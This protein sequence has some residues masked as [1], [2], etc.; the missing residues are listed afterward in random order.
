MGRGQP[1][2]LARRNSWGSFCQGTGKPHFG[3][4]PHRVGEG[5]K[6][7]TYEALPEP[8]CRSPSVRRAPHALGER[9]EL[10]GRGGEGRQ[11]GMRGPAGRLFFSFFLTEESYWSIFGQPDTSLG[12]DEVGSAE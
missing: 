5:A 8:R 11:E 7:Q 2:A 1:L 12:R 9:R 10:R 6:T 4:G 3:V